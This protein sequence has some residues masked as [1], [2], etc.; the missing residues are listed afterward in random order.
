[1][2][3]TTAHAPAITDSA[4]TPDQR[5][6]RVMLSQETPVTADTRVAI[7]NAKDLVRAAMVMGSLPSTTEEPRCPAA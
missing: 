6:M 3:N 5:D 1:M 2:G 4:R 7:L